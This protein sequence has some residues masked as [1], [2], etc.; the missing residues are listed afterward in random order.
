MKIEVG[1][2]IYVIDSG[3]K[4]VL[5][6]RVNEQITTKKIDGEKTTH[7]VEFPNGKVTVLESLDVLHFRGVEEVRE[8]L[9]ARAQQVIDE[10]I[11][12]AEQ[13]AG[14]KFGAPVI[15]SP[16]SSPQLSPEEAG[17]MQ[18]TLPDGKTANVN[19]KIPQEF[20]DEN[21]SS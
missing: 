8:H 19:I 18:V 20:I 14:E 13:V 16:I 2:V 11:S 15:A 3:Q 6:A 7:T 17:K 1:T 21:F 12:Q 9:L 10:G 4:V 5:P